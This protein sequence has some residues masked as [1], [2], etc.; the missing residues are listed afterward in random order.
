MLRTALLAALACAGTVSAAAPPAAADYLYTGKLAEG[1]KALVRHLETRPTDDEARFGLGA[2]RFLRSFEKL[3]TGLHTYGLRTQTFFPG[4]PRELQKLAPQNDKPKKINHAAFRKLV[5]EFVE[6][7]DSA[8]KVLGEIK[9]ERVKMPLEVG[10]IQIDL[11]GNG[12]PISA[13][14]LFRQFELTDEAKMAEKLVVGFDRGDAAWLSGYCHLLAGLGEMYLA[15][16]TQEAFNATAHRFFADADTPYKFL[17]EDYQEPDVRGWWGR[18]QKFW[19]DALQFVYHVFDMPI[20]EPKRLEKSLAHFEATVQQAE[21]MWVSILAET[22]DDNEW[23]PNPRQTGV[24]KIAVTNEMV[25]AW[26]ESALVEAKA[27]LAGKKLLPFW[28]GTQDRGVNLRK[29]FTDPPRRLDIPR[30]IQGTA[31]APYLE[32]GDLTKLADPRRLDSLNRA[33]GGGGRV[34]GFALWFN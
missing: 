10:R 5:E 9:D 14:I 23:I 20:G 29:V 15:L 31:A 16:D 13:A 25:T 2:V 18:D 6:S 26:R 30:W 27:I 34:F 3:G 19:F 1:E 33:F 8:A 7:L 11:W 28:R 22:D 24:L 4:M 32:K 21:L 17:L 12:T